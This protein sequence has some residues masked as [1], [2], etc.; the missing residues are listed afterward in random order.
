MLWL[1]GDRPLTG[2][3]GGKVITVVV[4]VVPFSSD[5]CWD[6]STGMTLC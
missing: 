2:L 3:F 6:G 4:V 5:S 1:G